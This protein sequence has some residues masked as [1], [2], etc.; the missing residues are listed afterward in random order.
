VGVPRSQG[1]K[2]PS[3]QRA[4]HLSAWEVGG[5]DS[6]CERRRSWFWVAIV[7]Y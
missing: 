3:A 5:W 1:M 4:S 2:V 7:I 6:K